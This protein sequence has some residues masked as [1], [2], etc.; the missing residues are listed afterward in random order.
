M[1]GDKQSGESDP[2][3]KAKSGR[4]KK[5]WGFKVPIGYNKQIKTAKALIIQQYTQKR[6]GWG[7]GKC[8]SIFILY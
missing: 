6:A 3:Q 5:F 7:A 8:E 4:N 1:A 2:V